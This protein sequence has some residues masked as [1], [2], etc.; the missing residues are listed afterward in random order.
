MRIIQ[1]ILTITALVLIA[2]G[3]QKPTF[4]S[5]RQV[6]ELRERINKLS[7]DLRAIRGVTTDADPTHL[8]IRAEIDGYIRTAFSPPQTTSNDVEER[9][10]AILADHIPNP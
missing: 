10:R 6:Q 3:R 2:A 9:L 4:D 8:K 5:D 7:E 1:F